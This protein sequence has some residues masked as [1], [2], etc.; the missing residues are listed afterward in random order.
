MDLE[1]YFD[2]FKQG[3]DGNVFWIDV[4]A[5]MEDAIGKAQKS[6]SVEALPHVIVNSRTGEKIVV[7]PNESKSAPSARSCG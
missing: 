4:A 3:T 2:I 5:N 1:P 7:S 6:M